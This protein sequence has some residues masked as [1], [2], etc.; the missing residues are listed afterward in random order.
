MSAPVF[1]AEPAVLAAAAPGL[2]VAVMGP[3]AR[4]AV[5][6]V[7]IRVGE[8]IVL[9]DGS[10]RRA[11][12]SVAVATAPDHLEVDIESVIDEPQPQPRFVVAQAIAKGEHAELAVDLMT[13]LG[14]DEVIPWQ[15]SRCVVRWNADKAERAEAKWRAAAVQAAKQSRRARVPQVGAP[16]ALDAL[17]ER[18]RSASTAIVL[19]EEA[20][21]SFIEVPLPRVGDVLLIVG[22][23]GGIADE[24]RAA[25]VAAGAREAVLGP[26]VLRSSLAGAAALAVL[27]SRLRW[28]AQDMEGSGA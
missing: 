4:H 10:G 13:Q 15:A 2:R 28:D 20:R 6:V 22:P 14:V 12:G 27:A 23:E 11:N 5:T 16:I 1:I 8:R 17:C 21:W 19:H 25:L 3:D 9:V 18:V 24:E 26:M 7:R